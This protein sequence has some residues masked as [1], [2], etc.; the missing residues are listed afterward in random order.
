VDGSAARWIVIFKRLT[1][2]DHHSGPSQLAPAITPADERWLWISVALGG[3]ISSA[4]SVQ[5][6]ARTIIRIELRAAFK[7]LCP[8]YGG[9]LKLKH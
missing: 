4:F 7:S 1:G 8:S 2:D 5:I 6:H 9:E 3:F